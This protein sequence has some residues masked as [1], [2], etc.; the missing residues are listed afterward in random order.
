MSNVWHTITEPTRAGN[1]FSATATFPVNTRYFD[2]HF[3]GRPILPGVAQLCAIHE[4][5]GAALPLLGSTGFCA[6]F[7]RVRFRKLIETAC[8]LQLSLTFQEGSD[9]VAFV[10]TLADEVC[11]E[12]VCLVGTPEPGLTARDSYAR[13]EPAS[14]VAIPAGGLVPHRDSMLLIDE[15]LE[16]DEEHCLVG[17]IPRESWPATAAHGTL[18]SVCV[19]VG[20]QAAAALAASIAGPYDKTI[21]V[22]AGIRK[23]TWNR[24]FIA[25]GRPIRII[26]RKTQSI[27][28]YG[29]FTTELATD[30]GFHAEVVLQAFRATLDFDFSETPLSA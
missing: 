10:V 27:G 16:A 18:S 30:D 25:T 9:D 29:V 2:G 21:G 11:C 24:P 5:L 3:H 6:G 15:V 1:L 28:S 14:A 19:E 4:L 7:R 23:A 13:F 8:S 17:S 26:A 20:A 12:G 22:L